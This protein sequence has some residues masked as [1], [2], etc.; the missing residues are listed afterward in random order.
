MKEG[1]GAVR[2]WKRLDAICMI[3][4]EQ[5]TAVSRSVRLEPKN[6]EIYIYTEEQIICSSS[7][8]N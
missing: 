6:R 8:F 2:R 5:K 1:G 4:D 3:K 7:Y